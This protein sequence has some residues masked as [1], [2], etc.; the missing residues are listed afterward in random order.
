MAYRVDDRSLAASVVSMESEYTPPEM[1]EKEKSR[2]KKVPRARPPETKSREVTEKSPS[3]RGI[4]SRLRSRSKKRDETKIAVSARPKLHRRSSSK[5]P[6]PPPA[7][8]KDER[9]EKRATHKS[10]EVSTWT[11]MKPFLP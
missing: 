7:R 4:F 3:K 5:V 1:R 6:P 9:K 11:T 8:E 10:R 2:K